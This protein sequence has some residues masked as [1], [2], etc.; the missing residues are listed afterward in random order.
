M[1]SVV[2]A[3]LQFRYLVIIIAAVVMIARVI[4]L[5]EA[6]TLISLI[7]VFTGIRLVT[8]LEN[9]MA[10]NIVAMPFTSEHPVTTTCHVQVSKLTM[11]GG[12]YLC[13]E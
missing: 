3:S 4:Q 10:R 8:G 5:G 2:R 12:I 6:Q 7:I 13:A 1:R 9:A 11:Q